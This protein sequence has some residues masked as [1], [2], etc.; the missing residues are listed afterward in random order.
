MGI[1]PLFAI[2]NELNFNN[3]R[4][5]YIIPV[6]VAITLILTFAQGIFTLFTFI[7]LLAVGYLFHNP[8]IGT[9][10]A[11]IA[12]AISFFLASLFAGSFLL[13]IPYTLLGAVNGGV[14]GLIG[15]Y[16]KKIRSPR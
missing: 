14:C 8:I 6:I 11:I 16:L 1:N 9:K 4:W 10:N 3:V 7:I 13:I 12:G 15:G 2:K 5:T